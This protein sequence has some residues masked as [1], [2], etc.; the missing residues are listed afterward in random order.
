M[1]LQSWFNNVA[2]TQENVAAMA[3]FFRQIRRG[4]LSSATRMM[5]MPVRAR[6]IAVSLVG[7]L[8]FAFVSTVSAQTN[9]YS[10]NG[11]E[12][13]VIGSL[14]GDQVFPDAAIS[15]TNGFVVWQDNATDGDGWGISARRMDSTLSG[16]LGTFRVNATGAG[17]QEN[18]HVALLKK[19]GAAFV[20]QGGR[21]GFQHIYARFLTASNTFLSTNDILV[22]TFASNFQIN[23]ALAVL[24]NGNVVVVWASYGQVNSN[25]MQDVYGQ[26]LSTN[27][28]KI[29]TNFLVNQFISFN[30]RTPT[31]AALKNGG[32]VVGWISEQQRQPVPLLGTNATYASAL[33]GP[34]PSVDLYARLFNASGAATTSEFMA[35]T[36]VNPCANPA[37]AVATDGS[38]LLAWGEHD[39]ADQTNGWD[40]YVRPFTSA[41]VGGT[42]TVVNTHTY[43]DQYIPRISCIG[44]DYLVAWT[45]LGQDGSREGVFAQFVHNNG[46]PVGGE[47]RVNTTTP[48]QQMQPAVASDGVSQFLAVWTSFVG[49][50]NGFDLY[51]QRFMNVASVLQ[52][53]SAPYVWVPF[54][55]SNNVYQPR[56]VVSWAPLLG[57]S[58]AN[59]EVYVDGASSPT[60]VVASNSWAMMAANG[61]TGNNTHSFQV[62]Y[63]TTDG[64][65]APISPSASG[66][67][68]SG[69]NWGGIP[70]EWMI[71]YYGSD[72]SQWPSAGTK[73]APN[74]TLYQVFLSGG[75]PLA[76]TTWLHQELARTGQGM[77]LDWNTQPGATYQ[78]Q[79][80]TN[81]TVWRSLGSPRFAAGATDSIYVGGGAASYYRIVLLR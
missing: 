62:D 24:T 13:A 19:G 3:G 48:G 49:S 16:T 38:F 67:T 66:T 61:L 69:L 55:V 26:I 39:R 50:P 45:S 14:P 35:N 11:A 53:M 54:T 43:G 64:R 51:A 59:F 31:V 78:V 70:S 58:V 2:D 21:P 60:G 57:L 47:F 37:A 8:V 5:F 41:G 28:A 20:W 76:S 75:S 23:P 33:T 34:T 79:V 9:Y 17:S 73:L 72:I 1:N 42:V 71:A 80:T 25:S 36:G 52:P 77:F 63:I 29:G 30:Q 40:I 44:I 12:Y 18:P 46:V 65:R 10:A 68:W 56:L 4:G 7:A 15:P 22:S 32:F 6:S 27:G 81:F 74:M